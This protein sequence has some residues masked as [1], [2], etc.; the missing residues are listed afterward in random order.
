MA[1]DRTAEAVDILLA[2]FP[3]FPGSSA[4]EP[5]EESR[6]ARIL[7]ERTVES[8]LAVGQVD[9]WGDPPVGIAVWLR[10]PA[11]GEPE[12]MGP[13]RPNLRATLPVEV[14][15]PLARFEATM[16]RLRTISRPDRHVYL[17]M[18]AVLPG[19]RRQGVATAL[20]EAGHRWA[21]DLG[22]PVALDT[23]TDENV[24]FYERRGYR[25]IGRERLPDSNR[26]LTAMRRLRT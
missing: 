8:G 17:D 21:D 22:L 10:R 20:I 4:L 18:L 25:V 19:H 14:I 5:A 23:D 26:D 11:L 15:E 7:H 24:T 13:A 16:Q 6:I 9:V 3:D 2:V 12:I 1:P